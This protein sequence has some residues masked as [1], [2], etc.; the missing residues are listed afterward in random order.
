MEATVPCA[1]SYATAAAAAAAAAA[2][3]GVWTMIVSGQS[4]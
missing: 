4:I 2:V 3:C 1:L